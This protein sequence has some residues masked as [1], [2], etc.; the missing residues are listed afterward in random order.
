VRDSKKLVRGTKEEAGKEFVHRGRML[1]ES[2]QRPDPNTEAP[3]IPV[4]LLVAFTRRLIH[5][6]VSGD[7]IYLAAASAK[8]DVEATDEEWKQLTEILMAEHKKNRVWPEGF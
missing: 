6:T 4:Q 7:A 3:Q 2:K 5:E 8:R 1:C